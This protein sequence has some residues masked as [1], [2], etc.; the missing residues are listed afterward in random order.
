MLTREPGTDPESIPAI[1]GTAILFP[2]RRVWL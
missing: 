1:Y 2:D